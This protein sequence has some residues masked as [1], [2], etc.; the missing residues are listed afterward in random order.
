MS[1]NIFRRK[2][3]EPKYET[4]RSYFVKPLSQIKTKEEART[5]AIDYQNWASRE[6]LSYSEIAKHQDYFEKLGKKFKLTEEF[7][8]NGI[9]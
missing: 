9:I 8:E 6:N 4:D 5:M 7:K 1:Y 2:V 3:K